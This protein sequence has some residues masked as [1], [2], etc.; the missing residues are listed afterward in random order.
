MFIV[1]KSFFSESLCK[2]N[3]KTI[4]TLCF[5]HIPLKM[6]AVWPFAGIYS[7]GLNI[8]LQAHNN[9][10]RIHIG[11][12]YDKNI[13]LG[14]ELMLKKEGSKN[15]FRILQCRDINI[16]ALQGILIDHAC[17]VEP[18]I[19]RQKCY[20]GNCSKSSLHIV[21]AWKNLRNLTDL[22]K[23]ANPNSWGREQLHSLIEKCSDSLRLIN[24]RRVM[25]FIKV[26]FAIKNLEKWNDM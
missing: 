8:S 24:C 25:K 22:A 9:N 16:D 4:P 15:F 10:F 6:L 21:M 5:I 2:L 12:A 1:G 14:F 11:C 26:F 19:L 18:C 3:I 20:N 13:T 23:L 17:L 7:L